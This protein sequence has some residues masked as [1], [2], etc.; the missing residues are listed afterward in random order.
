MSAS[1]D[2]TLLRDQHGYAER[3]NIAVVDQY[4]HHTGEDR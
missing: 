1:F 2:L 4:A 3:Q